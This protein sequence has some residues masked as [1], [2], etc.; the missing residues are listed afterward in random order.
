MCTLHWLK[1]EKGVLCNVLEMFKPAHKRFLDFV[2]FL[3]ADQLTEEQIA[4]MVINMSSLSIS[5]PPFLSFFFFFFNNAPILS[6]HTLCCMVSCSP[7]S[8]LCAVRLSS[9][10]FPFKVGLWTSLCWLTGCICGLVQ[11]K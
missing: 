6:L 11:K 4:G 5:P 9:L 8:N 2:Y 10:L 1:K 7:A 3:Q